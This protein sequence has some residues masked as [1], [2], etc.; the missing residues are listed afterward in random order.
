MGGM[1]MSIPTHLFACIYLGDFPVQA[2]LRMHS[3]LN[4][5]SC[6]V[7]D[8]EP[9]FQQVCSLNSK[10]QSIGVEDGMTRVEV[11]TF[12]GVT[13][14]LRDL[15]AEQAARDLLLECA[16]TFSPHVEYININTNHLLCI[17]ISGTEQLFGSPETFARKVLGRVN[18]LGFTASIAISHNFHA[19]ACLAKG[20]LSHNDFRVIA[21]GHEA[22][23]LA[24]LP[25]SVLDVTDEQAKTLSLWG[26]HTLGMLANLPEAELIARMEGGQR[27]CQ[28]ARGTLPHLFQPIERPFI[29]EDRLDLDTPV[30]LLDSLLFVMGSMLDHL[31]ERAKE[32]M[33]ALAS[34]SITLSLQRGA[35][36]SRTVRPAA[37]TTDKQVWLKLLHL[38][39]EAHPP[40]AAI[41][42][43]ALKGEPGIS[44]K[45]Q[46]GIFSPQL[47]ET[48]RLDV[49]LARIRAIVGEDNVGRVV[50][51]DTHAAD[52]FR[53]EPFTVSPGTP[54]SSILPQHRMAMRQLRPPET[55]S[56]TLHNSRLISFCF[57][58]C[59]YLVTH[60]Y[61]PWLVD[62]DWWNRTIWRS[63][64]WDI[65]A[66]EEN[67]SPLCGCMMRDL[68]HDSW[69]MV[70]LYD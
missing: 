36:H 58:E 35:A 5:H 45:I 4:N 56:I 46:L 55:V 67:G 42:A 61:G 16:W 13:I 21:P 25:L 18:A 2:L 19:A 70:S 50:L 64:Q 28:M 26:I 31:L 10:A 7:L 39:L 8:G 63:E 27:L 54:V 6:V 51:T 57:R 53:I 3:E 47:P 52:S 22:E 14:L 43:V 68:L 1:P 44:N 24:S 60:A 48:T 69:Q 32:H 41:T 65:V 17:D 33:L 37:P 11:D 62:G 12:S 38:D 34:I 40:R 30:D 66:R 9:P 23:S 20:L 29:L 49:T 15:Q 59:R